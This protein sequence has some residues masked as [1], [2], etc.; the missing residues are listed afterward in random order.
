M[1]LSI[2]TVAALLVITPAVTA[3]RFDTTPDVEKRI[4]ALLAQMTLEE[5]VGQLNQFSSTFDVT[6]P[7]P[8]AGAARD[9]YELLRSGRVG[10]LLKS[11]APTR[12]ARRSRS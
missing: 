2:L 8:Q 10:S 3:Q 7:A 12:L 1:R 9:R 6:G 5:K 11:W 4:D